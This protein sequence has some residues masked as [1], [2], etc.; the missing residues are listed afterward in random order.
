MK[1]SSS[2]RCEIAKY[3]DQH[4]AAE[5]AR[6]FSRK[7]GKSVSESTMKSIKKAYVK[8]NL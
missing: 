6:H 8:V 4:A 1:L 2:Q 7:L 5:I 3:A